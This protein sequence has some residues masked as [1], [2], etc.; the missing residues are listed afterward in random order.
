MASLPADPLMSVLPLELVEEIFSLCVAP[1]DTDHHRDHRALSHIPIYLSRVSK[2]WRNVVCATPALWTN[3]C[4][5]NPGLSSDVSA[6]QAHLRY[7]RDH[8]LAV[9]L[10]LDTNCPDAIECV[11]ATM[12][13]LFDHS[14]RIRTLRLLAM[15]QF[16][17]N[18][19][20]PA[21][22][23]PQLQR[24]E[25]NAVEHCAEYFRPIMLSAPRLRKVVWCTPSY[26][27]PL[28]H[29]GSQLTELSLLHCCCNYLQTAAIL[30]ECPKLTF[31][32]VRLAEQI[33]SVRYIS[34][35][36]LEELKILRATEFAM[37]T[38]LA[39]NLRRLTF[40]GYDSNI[41]SLLS[42]LPLSP[43]LEELSL[44]LRTQT[45]D[46]V[47]EIASCAPPSLITLEVSFYSTYSYAMT[48][49]TLKFLTWGGPGPSVLPNLQ[50]LTLGASSSWRQTE[51]AFHI[52]DDVLVAMLASRCHGASCHNT[53][54]SHPVDILESSNHMPC[55]AAPVAPLRSFVM[56]GGGTLAAETRQRLEP[57]R[58][59]GL[60]LGGDFITPT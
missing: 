27:E 54:P 6:L 7:S 18:S 53:D 57:L 35:V 4:I 11:D 39:P 41:S 44:D 48:D 49:L 52:Q 37:R 40:I 31:L 12:A 30:R 24:V 55:S 43:H 36:L 5:H 47:I 13:A 28:L 32:D 50:H 8:A 19:P 23:F 21:H 34:R 22:G 42:F 29:I 26:P 9:C 56:N 10:V 45:E 1:A 17:W 58:E 3:V 60:I 33:T 59:Q 46:R 2:I 20:V 25:I 15:C 51:Q 38:C 14:I 16:L